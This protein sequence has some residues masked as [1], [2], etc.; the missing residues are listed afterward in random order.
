MTFEIKGSKPT[1]RSDPQLKQQ[2]SIYKTAATMTMNNYQESSMPNP[3][4][5]QP[6]PFATQEPTVLQS[7]GNVQGYTYEMYRVNR[8]AYKPNP[9]WQRPARYPVP[10]P[11]KELNKKQSFLYNPTIRCDACQQR[12]HPAVRCHALAAALCLQQFLCKSLLMILKSDLG[13]I[14]C[15]E[16]PLFSAT[17]KHTR[18]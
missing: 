13:I 18:H 17:P 16:M 1:E 3:T 10:D 11:S 5:H 15:L 2:P 6:I 8:A 9:E 12:G 4:T 7:K 14:G